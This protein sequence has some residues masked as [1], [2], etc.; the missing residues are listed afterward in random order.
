MVVVKSHYDTTIAP[1]LEAL[2]RKHF[3]SDPD[4]P[5]ILHRSDIVQR[6]RW[7]GVLREPARAQAWD[8][9]LLAFIQELHAQL[10]TI[11]IDKWAHKQAY[12]VSTF[13]PYEYALAVLLNRIRG[14]LNIQRAQAD[15]TAD[16]R[17]KREDADLQRAYRNLRKVG[18]GAY[19]SAAEYQHV[20]PGDD[21]LIRQKD[22]NVAGLQVADLLVTEQ[23]LDITIRTGKP[24]TNQPSS[25]VQRLITAASHMINGY[26]R[27]WLE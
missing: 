9:D 25:M 18:G 23:K 22:S 19:D 1:A 16:G 26:G 4:N 10:F 24:V 3:A 17:G 13:D 12:P 21:L 6:R 27:I 7:F 11:V 14:F 5:V 2:K 15:T 8:D 20:F